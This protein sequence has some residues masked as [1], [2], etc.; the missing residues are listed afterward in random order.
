MRKWSL[1]PILAVLSVTAAAQNH[2]AAEKAAKPSA[3]IC[4][5][6]VNLVNVVT[7][8]MDADQT[9]L[10]ENDRITAT[11]PSKKIKAPANATLVD[12]TGKYLMPGMTDAHIHFFQSGACTPAP[13]A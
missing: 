2:P 13:M 4:I 11:G 10:I 7:G 1:I 8:K 6:H 9:V 3:P 5:S 12:G